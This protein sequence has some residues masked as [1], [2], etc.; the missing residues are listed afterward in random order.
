[1]T[2]VDSRD[3]R[4]YTVSLTLQGRALHDRI[5]QLAMER[6]RRLLKDLTPAD[7]FIQSDHLA[8]SQLRQRS[9]QVQVMAGRKLP[10]LVRY[11]LSYL[12]EQLTTA[13]QDPRFSIPALPSD[14]A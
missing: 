10:V 8:D 14:S 1:M 9:L 11:F 3:A 5:F 12:E 4:R 2:A 7:V 13:T 6:E